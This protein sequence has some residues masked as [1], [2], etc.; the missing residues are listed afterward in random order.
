M[1]T[2][3]IAVPRAL[4]S[5]LGLVAAKESDD[6]VSDQSTAIEKTRQLVDEIIAASY[7]ELRGVEIQFKLFQDRAD[8][9]RTRFAIPQL[10][11]SPGCAT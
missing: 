2:L 8:F 9:F 4:D 5:D 6:Q 3:T 11:F 1:F 10:F 7:P